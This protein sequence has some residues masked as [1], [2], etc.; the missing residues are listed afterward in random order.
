MAALGSAFVTAW[1]LAVLVGW[2]LTATALLAWTWIE[3]GRFDAVSTARE[4]TREDDSRAAARAVL[5][6]SSVLS[7]GAIVTALHRASTAALSLEVALISAS[8]L[9]VVVSWL[10]VSTVFTLRYAHLYYGGSAAGGIEFPGTAAPSYRDFAYLAFTVGMTFQVSD[11]AV[12]EGPVRATVMRHGL[13]SF[14]FSIAIIALTI[15]VVA[16]LVG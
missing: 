1:E 13:L 11:T 12:T 14:A 9:T 15:N 8:L 6:A 5:V 2:I 16:G 3:V 7:L 10:V 4:A